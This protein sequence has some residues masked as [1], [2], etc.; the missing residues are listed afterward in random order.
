MTNFRRQC[1]QRNSRLIEVLS[2]WGALDTQQITLLLFPSSRVAQRRLKALT[3]KGRIQRNTQTLPYFYYVEKQ[4]NPIERIAVNWARLWLERQCKSWER[5]S[6]DYQVGICTV[7]N[8]ITG[9]TREIRIAENGFKLPS[10]HV[11]T[12]T[13][14]LINQWRGKLLCEKSS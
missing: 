11:L 1:Y 13:D 3:E 9:A 12:I 8:I 10:D 7:T 4:T 14:D 6:M 5:I 2:E